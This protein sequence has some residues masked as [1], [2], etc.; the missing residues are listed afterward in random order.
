[1]G[2]FKR[3]KKTEEPEYV[4][5]ATVPDT[6]ASGIFQEILRDNGIPFIS[7]QMGAGGCVK[8]ITG[9]LLAPDDI[10]VSPEHSERATELYN[11]YLKTE[12]YP[13]EIQE[14]N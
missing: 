2:L 12:A 9:G 3:R 14:E 5:V 10:Y 11:A 4:L 1:M 7:R 13:E 6:V 8:L